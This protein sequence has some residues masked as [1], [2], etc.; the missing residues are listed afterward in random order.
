MDFLR[1]R[2]VQYAILILGV[3]AGLNLIWMYVLPKHEKEPS[4][5][6]LRAVLS[7]GADSSGAQGA[8]VDSELSLKRAQAADKLGALHDMDSVPV[9][10]KAMDDP[11]L[12]VRGRAGV[13]VREIM[14]SDSL[15]R[16]SDP[17]EQ[18]KKRIEQIRRDWETFQK[19]RSKNGELPTRTRPPTRWKGAQP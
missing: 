19:Y 17:P 11:D 16:P 8:T 5:E 1:N 13:A 2:R 4:V 18:R 3:L 7:Q 12:L 14:G 6:E 10:L 9:L 15:Y